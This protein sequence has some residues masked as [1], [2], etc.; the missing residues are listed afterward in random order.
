MGN[1]SVLFKHMI[2][3][4]IYLFGNLIVGEIF[5]P[6]YRLKYLPILVN[7]NTEYYLFEI[8][9]KEVVNIKIFKKT[10]SFKELK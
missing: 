2:T 10:N 1:L 6:F 5:K 8:N 3:L 9:R 7:E 4:I